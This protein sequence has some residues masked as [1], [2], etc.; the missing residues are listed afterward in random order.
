MNLFLLTKNNLIKF[1]YN[2]LFLYPA[3][4]NL[5]YFWNFGIYGLIA[6]IV[7]LLTGILLAMHY[8]SHIDYAFLSIE[9]IMRNVNFGWLLRYIHSNG[10]SLFF[11][12]IYIHIFRGLFF[13]SFLYP[14]ELLW[15][16]GVII[17]ILMIITAFFGYVL[18]WGLR[19]LAQNEFLIII[20]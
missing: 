9:H 6:L 11:I 8:I 10:A 2:L 14:R 3:P 13:G 19:N 5:T 18:P 1:F 16:V 15:V 4:A 12:V 7:Q 20:I 17:F